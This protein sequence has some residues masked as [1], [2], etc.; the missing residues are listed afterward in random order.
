MTPE[1][2]Q[3]T[4]KAYFETQ[5]KMDADA[6][7]ALFTEDAVI[8]DPVGNPA[9]LV[10][11]TYQKFF[12][13]L[14]MTFEQLELLPEQIFVA[15]NGAAVKWRMRGQAKTGKQTTAEGIS[16]FDLKDNKIQRVSAYWD[17]KAMM[18]QLQ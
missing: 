8:Y 14:T 17:D 13:L 15:G 12:A 16:V 5:Q 3:A 4:V 11:E 9:N 10:K 18:A 7:L 6:W 2:I 1:M